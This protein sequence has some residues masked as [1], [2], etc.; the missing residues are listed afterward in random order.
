MRHTSSTASWS[1]GRDGGHSQ[2]STTA[3]MTRHETGRG[4]RQA[5]PQ[6][7]REE[8][9]RQQGRKMKWRVGGAHNGRWR[10][11]HEKGVE[12]GMKESTE[13]RRRRVMNDQ[14]DREEQGDEEGDEG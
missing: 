1:R 10:S 9:G 8:V 6:E 11:G 2:E 5:E 3:Q 4:R 12:K 14:A 13:P 7:R